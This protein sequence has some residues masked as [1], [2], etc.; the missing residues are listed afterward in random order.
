MADFR[1][2]ASEL[3]ACF[4]A[5]KA[6]IQQYKCVHRMAVTVVALHVSSKIIDY[7][8]TKYA[9]KPMEQLQN[10]VTQY[11]L[12][13]RRLEL[14]E[15]SAKEDGECKC[16]GDEHPA[17]SA[18]R[19]LSIDEIRKR[20][21]A[22]LFR[23]Q[24]AANRAKWI[25]STEAALYVH[26]EQQH[27]SSHTEVPMFLSKALFMVQECKRL[28]SGNK[29]V[30]T[31]AA[32]TDNFDVI[33]Y[34]MNDSAAVFSRPIAPTPLYNVQNSCFFNAII[35]CLKRILNILP[36]S[37]FPQCSNCPLAEPL[38]QHA[39]TPNDIEAWTAWT[40]VPK[41]IQ[42]DAS[43]VLEQCMDSGAVMHAS[44]DPDEC[45]AT[46]LRKLTSFRLTHTTRCANCTE[47]TEEVQEQCILRLEPGCG[48]AN[49]A[50]KRSIDDAQ[51]SLT[52]RFGTAALD[53]TCSHCEANV[54][55]QTTILG[56]TPE[57]L[58]VHMKKYA[59][60]AGPTAQPTLIVN[61]TQMD[62]IA[63]IHLDGN[64]PDDGH[65]TATV[66]TCN[67]E[68]YLCND[69]I[70]RSQRYQT[71]QPWENCFL[72]FLHRRMNYVKQ[73]EITEKEDDD[74]EH[75]Q[76]DA[77]SLPPVEC[78]DVDHESKADVVTAGNADEATMHGTELRATST[79]FDDWLHRGPYLADLPW[80][81]YMMRVQR[82][83]KPLDPLSTYR[84][85]FF[86]DRHYGLA[87]LYC[88]RIDYYRPANVPRIIGSECPT[89]DAESGESH[90]A[91]KLML[92]SRV[93]CSGRDHCAD[94]C[95]FRSM[96]CP[97]DRYQ[98]PTPA[99]EAM[100]R[101]QLQ[102][103]RNVILTYATTRRSLL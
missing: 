78:E 64:A 58:I 98:I 102:P 103:S 92:M 26:T 31:R 10:L 48:C 19:K 66:T 61:D 44:C 43:Q 23:L 85:L 88:Q 74:E 13:L 67:G 69:E 52:Q 40:F 30:L 96:L 25:S 62:R 9:A 4:R 38:T 35:Q 70:I 81:V 18:K 94:P 11:A 6:A 63:A 93:R 84:E 87:A 15:E 24:H 3:A 71:C 28:L 83:R 20:A 49:S 80:H 16:G 76:E 77:E 2:D 27:W 100:F 21:R 89:A 22:V 60:R 55:Q 50:A 36:T 33:D 41:N 34:R 29:S 39:P 65:Y 42:Q 101:C 90:A 72:L 86:F 73:E 68:T 95:I 7:Y 59:N 12:G 1:I 82:V 57:V 56:E 53:Y 14:E 32:T 51:N 45:Y 79:R 46:L 91:Y 75:L 54:A 8:I 17:T 47:T 97:N 37:M 99:R 5:M